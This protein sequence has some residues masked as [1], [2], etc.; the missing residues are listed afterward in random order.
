MSEARQAYEMITNNR[1]VTGQQSYRVSAGGD[2]E[3]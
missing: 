1:P 2:V 3:C